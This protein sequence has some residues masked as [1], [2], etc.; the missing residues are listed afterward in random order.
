MN[1]TE[2]L[3]QEVRNFI[4]DNKEYQRKVENF[5]INNNYRVLQEL[6]KDDCL[7]ILALLDEP[8]YMKVKNNIETMQLK[9]EMEEAIECINDF[10]DNNNDDYVTFAKYSF[11]EYNSIFLISKKILITVSS[12]NSNNPFHNYETKSDKMYWS[13][14]IVKCQ[15]N[16]NIN[17]IENDEIFTHLLNNNCPVFNVNN[18][19]RA[20]KVLES[21]K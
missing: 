11:D 20:N 14:F 21:F 6:Q 12:I 5:L 8:H 15:F 19:Y 17:L 7:E 4:A 9:Q 16:D 18:S 13:N 3:I 2:S 10:L 1:V